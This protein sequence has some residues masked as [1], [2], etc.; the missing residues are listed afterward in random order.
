V[1]RIRQKGFTI[2]ELMIVVVI[3]GVLMMVALPAY[4]DSLQKGRRA[5]GMAALMDAAGRQEKFMLDRSTYTEDMAD[6]GYV[7][8]EGEVDY[9][10]PEGHYS[11]AATACDDGVITNCYELT[12]EPAPGSVQLK[13]K[14]CTSFILNSNGTKGATG[15]L[16]SECW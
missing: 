11:I 14:K 16:A 3:V 2:I 13:D 1:N 15:S 12:A 8:T 9:I 5:D 7:T 10:S 4:Q 6:L